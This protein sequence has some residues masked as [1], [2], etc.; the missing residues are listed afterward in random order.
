MSLT[1]VNITILV[2]TMTGTAQL[3]AQE[4][5]LAW[6]DGE[7][8]VET[9]VMDGLDCKVFERPGVFLICTSTYGQGDV[10]DNAKALYADLQAKRPNL[11]QVRY[12][13]FGLGDRT[14]AETFNFGGKRFDDLLCELG[15]QRIGERVQHDASSGVLPEETAQEWGVEWLTLAREASAQAA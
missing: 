3:V 1:P 11:S 5:E 9:L 15:A 6:D 4:L 2:G 10:P 7:T 12:G 13:V 8:K 14:Y